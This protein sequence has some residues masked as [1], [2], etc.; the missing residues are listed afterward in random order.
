MNDTSV[1]VQGSRKSGTRPVA[2]VSAREITGARR[3]QVAPPALSIRLDQP[4][5]AADDM[6][7]AFW[8]VKKRDLE[9]HPKVALKSLLY[10][11][12]ECPPVRLYDVVE[13]GVPTDVVLLLA[14]AF[15]NTAAWAM[16]LIGVSETTF[17]RKEE[18][19][20]PL[21]EVA[22][23]RVMGFLRI[24]A[25]LQRLLDE[26]GDPALV[27]AFDL[28]S[29]VSDWI[30]NPLPELGGKTPADM[31]RNPEGQR[32]VVELLERMRGGLPA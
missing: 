29:W 8:E 10:R 28:E 25:T 17:R 19:N 9:R 12:K 21:P 32:A 20:E 14:G 22:G 3:G 27:A 31:L 2:A 4:S 26:S 23:H 24:V 16:N 6:P 1:P 30:R 7:F 11:V 15:G 13:C 18:A 5:C